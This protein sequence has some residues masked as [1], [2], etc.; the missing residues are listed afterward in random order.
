MFPKQLEC[1]LLAIVFSVNAGK[2]HDGINLL[3]VKA[4]PKEPQKCAL[5][6]L[7]KLFT[8]KELSE[9]ILFQSKRSLKPPLDE[10]RV[11]KMFDV[12]NAQYTAEKI[13]KYRQA[14]I[15]A[16]N[17]KCRDVARKELAGSASK[18]TN[19]TDNRGQ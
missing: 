3:N 2:W 5:H 15:D 18:C 16:C 9:G 4:P 14:I 1:A 7:D 12:L 8:K 10:A 17:Q 13:Q 11:S 19:D 6:L